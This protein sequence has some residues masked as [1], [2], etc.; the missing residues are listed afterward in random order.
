MSLPRIDWTKHMTI[1]K[2]T[3]N[4]R[5][6]GR[7]KKDNKEKKEVETITT[8]R[9]EASN[10]M[11]LPV[12]FNCVLPVDES[13]DLCIEISGTISNGCLECASFTSLEGKS[14]QPFGTFFYFFF[15]STACLF[16]FCF[17]FC[18]FIDLEGYEKM[19]AIICLN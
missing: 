18:W 7:L 6:V 5:F 16:C 2:N 9:L 13:I 12:N 19:L 8:Y 17:V 14:F 10:K 15:L 11:S 4:G 1:E 3:I